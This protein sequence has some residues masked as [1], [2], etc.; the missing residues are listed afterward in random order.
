MPLPP[1]G[2]TYPHMHQGVMQSRPGGFSFLRGYQL[3]LC[4]QRQ[5][6]TQ[7]THPP[8]EVRLV[9]DPHRTRLLKRGRFDLNRTT[10]TCDLAPQPVQLSGERRGESQ[11][12][13]HVRTPSQTLVNTRFVPTIGRTRRITDRVSAHS[14]GVIRRSESVNQGSRKDLRGSEGLPIA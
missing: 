12:G 11:D 5:T 9:R 2:L 4:Q 7:H 14:I 8:R 13:V 6:L 1:D 3:I 10:M